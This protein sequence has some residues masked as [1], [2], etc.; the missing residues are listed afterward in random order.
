MGRILR[1]EGVLSVGGFYECTGAS[2]NVPMS[3]AS[4]AKVRALFHKARGSV[5]FI[6][7]AY[8]MLQRGSGADNEAVAALIAEMENYRD[9]VV[10][11]LAGYEREIAELLASNPGFDSRERARGVMERAAAAEGFGN[12]RFARNLFENA[13]LRQSTWLASLGSAPSAEQLC[14][15][16]PE[17][18]E[19]S[20]PVKKPPIGFAPA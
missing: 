8:S 3:G 5:V 9:E 15:I 11:I 17:D 13:L 14:E 16:L 20:A 2:L 4:E 19:W 6:D 1:D 7:E 18:I 12:A 10:V